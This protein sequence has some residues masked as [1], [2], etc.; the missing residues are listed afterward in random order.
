[1]QRQSTE[2]PWVSIIDYVVATDA[3]GRWTADIIPPDAASVSLKL[4]HPEYADDYMWHTKDY[5]VEQLREQSAVMVM[6]RGVALCGRVV[7]GRGEPV[8]NAYVVD[9]RGLYSNTPQTMTDEKGRFDFGTIGQREVVL[10]VVAGGYGP[11][12]MRF[13]SATLTGPVEI[14]LGP[15]HTIAGRVVDCNGLA[16]AGATVMAR[17]WRGLE[18]LLWRAKVNEEG[19]FA[20]RGAP[21]DEVNIVAYADGYVDSGPIPMVADVREYKVV[22]LRELRVLGTVSDANTKK[23]IEQFRVIVGNRQ[24]QEHNI[25]WQVGNKFWDRIFTD[26]EFALSFNIPNEAYAIRIEA[27]GY[28]PLTSRQ[29]NIEEGDVRFEFA[30]EKAGSISG[31]VLLPDGTPA[32][33]A[34]VYVVRAGGYLSL[35]NG[36]R[37]IITGDYVTTGPDGGFS[38]GPQAEPYK[39]VA[40]HDA[41]FAELSQSQ[42]ERLGKVLLKPWG[43]VEV[44]LRKGTEP[45]EYHNVSLVNVQP[46]NDANRMY[47]TYGYTAVTDERGRCILERV[48]PCRM[49]VKWVSLD[50]GG[51][52]T[53][54]IEYGEIEVLPGRTVSLTFDSG[55]TTVVGKFEISDRIREFEGWTAPQS[56]F[57]ESRQPGIERLYERLH[58]PLPDRLGEMSF[59]EQARWYVTFLGS[60]EGQQFVERAAQKL[61]EEHR[62]W[63]EYCDVL[64]S[65][66]SFRAQEIPPGYY[67]LDVNCYR[68]VDEDTGTNGWELSGRLQHEFTVPENYDANVPLD[69]GIL[70]VGPVAGLKVG[71]KAPMLEVESA[72]R[73]RIRLSH[74]AGRVVL[75]CF[76]DMGM[77]SDG[78]GQMDVVGRIHRQFNG[79]SFDVLSVMMAAPVSPFVEMA[80]KYAGEHNIIWTQGFIDS[81]SIVRGMFEVGE[82]PWNVFVG[83]YGR[84]LAVGLKG[85][86]LEHAVAEALGE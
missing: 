25:I 22:L 21:S 58:L 4:S 80:K 53:A 17:G 26:G 5:T 50:D 11:E 35:R 75:I 8:S 16:I 67:I 7:N 70:T 42:F 33:G 59:D 83:P 27:N 45:Q 68:S 84:V 9:G 44:L 24:D 36:V 51:R 43:R 39:I 14:V 20:W 40:I 72:D 78:F 15:G 18:T 28:L 10:T 30:L 47:C 57:I 48:V 38:I 54:V 13:D 2:H 65:D 56:C 52:R 49:Q 12:L 41:G 46:E 85:E 71:E 34:E 31:S 69:L 60:S 81:N 79:E 19:R 76:W 77:S 64:E 66:Y 6:K 61:T 73:Q 63:K 82:L 29:V 32:A 3:N 23:P 37:S 1:M 62:P 86:K 74:F 55:R